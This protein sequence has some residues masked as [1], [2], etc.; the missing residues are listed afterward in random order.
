MK[1]IIKLNDLKYRYDVYQMF[2][3][4][5]PLDEIKFENMT[6]DNIYTKRIIRVMEAAGA[7]VEVIKKESL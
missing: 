5:Y 1:V 3:I 2:N 4:Y 7:E 6:D